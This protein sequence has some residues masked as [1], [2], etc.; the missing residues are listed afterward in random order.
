MEKRDYIEMVVNFLGDV[1]GSVPVIGGFLTAVKNTGIDI[2]KRKREEKVIEALSELKLRFNDVEDRFNNLVQ[3]E[4]FLF[5]FYKS[6]Y[7][8]GNSYDETEFK[9]YVNFISKYLNNNYDNDEMI[10]LF[11]VITKLNPVS[12]KLLKQIFNDKGCDWFN[13][14]KYYLPSKYDEHK[15]LGISYGD[16]DFK[17][18]HTLSE[19]IRYGVIQERHST[20]MDGS[21]MAYVEDIK[22]GEI[23]K[24]IIELLS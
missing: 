8:I 17:I 20:W 9:L 18:H 10:L 4:Q 2:V 19:L 22:I 15:K 21:D 1:S 7:N 16:I 6:I 3:N 24:Q 13:T 23:G 14:I 12:W 11:D 5:H